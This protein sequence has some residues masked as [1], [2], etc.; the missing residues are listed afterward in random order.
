MSARVRRPLR[1]TVKKGFSDRGRI[2]T[3]G[4][5]TSKSKQVIRRVGPSRKAGKQITSSVRVRQIASSQLPRRPI[6]PVRKAGT[7]PIRKGTPIRKVQAPR[8]QISS[9]KQPPPRDPLREIVFEVSGLNAIQ[10]SPEFQRFKNAQ[11]GTVISTVTLPSKSGKPEFFN[12]KRSFIDDFI[13]LTQASQQQFFNVGSQLAQATGFRR[14]PIAEQA[15][16]ALGN[17]LGFGGR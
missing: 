6:A 15:A 4:F 2:R 1:R 11:E 14:K 10:K 8:P 12:V 3:G 5:V 13:F 7:A 9:I 17:F 16:S